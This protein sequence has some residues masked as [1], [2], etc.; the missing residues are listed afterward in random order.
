MN[1]DKVKFLVMTRLD[2]KVPLSEQKLISKD[3]T[4]Y[5]LYGKFCIEKKER[6]GEREF[7]L[8]ETLNV[9]K[10]YFYKLITIRS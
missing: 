10:N 2:C 1:L 6:V 5:M 8:F 4:L 9:P 7:I 3:D